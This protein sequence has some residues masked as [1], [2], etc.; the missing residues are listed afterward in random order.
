MMTVREL[1][2]W[3]SE[4][5]GDLPVVIAEYQ[6]RGVDFAYDIDVIFGECTD[7]EIDSTYECVQIVTGVQIGTVRSN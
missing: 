2:N 1:I 5:D 4:F 6:G 3:L 7:W